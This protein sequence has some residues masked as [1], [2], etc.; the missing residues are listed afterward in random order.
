MLAEFVGTFALIFIG[1]GTIM[2]FTASNQGG[3]ALAAR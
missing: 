2:A 3:D 1:A